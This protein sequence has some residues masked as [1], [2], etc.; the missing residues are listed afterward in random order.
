M[1]SRY[2]K[3][4]G[5]VKIKDKLTGAQLGTVSHK[6]AAEGNAHITDFIFSSLKATGKSDTIKKLMLHKESDGKTAWYIAAEKG[7]K[8]ILEKL[9]C[10]GREVQVNLKDDL[11]LS[12]GFDGQTAWNIAAKKDNKEILEELRVWVM[13]AQLNIRN[14]LLPAKD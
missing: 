10:W 2:T 14:H 6:A 7:N 12:K 9:W 13:E 5:Y 3:Y 8:E 4:G 11:L 1:E